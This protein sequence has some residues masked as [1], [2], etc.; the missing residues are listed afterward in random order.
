MARFWVGGTGTWDSTTTTH[1]S[2]TTGGA[3][4]AS[5]P[6]TGETVTF[7]GASGGGTVSVSGTIS[8]LS[9]SG[10]DCGAFTGTLDFSSGNPNLTVSTNGSFSVSGTGTRTVNL[11]SGTF[12]LTGTNGNVWNATTTT[13][14]TFNAGT[15]TIVIGNGTDANSQS[16][17]T[18]GL[19]YATVSVL[20][21]TFGS[22]ITF[23]GASTTF[24]TFLIAGPAFVT[25]PTS[26]TITNP[27]AWNGSASGLIFVQINGGFPLAINNAVGSVGSWLAV[28]G[29]AFSNT[30]TITN[31]F[32]MKNNTGIS[33]TSPSV[34]GGIVGS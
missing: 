31:G 10:I 21:R 15:S 25:V 7:D 9:L 11:G 30:M 33:L 22:Q 5:V 3:G 12:T 19:T 26:L 1:W 29:L 13:G 8:G 27:L 20:G 17:V 28:K 18:G 4:G 6:G 23:T 34:G 32:D 14:L 16:F 2:L 24:T